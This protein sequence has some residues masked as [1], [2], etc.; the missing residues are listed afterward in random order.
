VESTLSG[1]SLRK[2]IQT[3][4]DRGY[5]TK[6][7]FVFVDSPESCLIRV[8]ERVARG[9]HNVPDEDVIRR[10]GRSLDNFWNVYRWVS[11]EWVLYYNGGEVPSRVASGSREDVLV[12]DESRFR[13]FLRLIGHERGV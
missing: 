9:G 1:L 3:A 4:L 5:H 12:D 10:F 13:F 6:I 11:S 2:S 8:R 7:L